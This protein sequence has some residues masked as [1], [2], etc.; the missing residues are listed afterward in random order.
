MPG[1]M[2]RLEHGDNPAY[3]ELYAQY[4]QWQVDHLNVVQPRF[5]SAEPVEAEASK[6]TGLPHKKRSKRRQRRQH[7]SNSQHTSGHR[8][9]PHASGDAPVLIAERSASVIGD[10]HGFG[11]GSP[12]KPNRCDGVRNFPTT[13]A[14]APVVRGCTES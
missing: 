12:P 5:A 4:S 2:S 3:R 14:N 11:S 1:L 10:V 13:V 6:S 7:S 9:R 8:E